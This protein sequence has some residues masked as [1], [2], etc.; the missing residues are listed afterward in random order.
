MGDFILPIGK[1]KVQR[2][3]SDITIVA[4]AR[5]MHESLIAADK[6]AEQGISAEVLNLRTIRPL[7][8]QAIVDSVKKTGRIITVEE[9]WPQSGVG[10]EIAAV[11]MESEAFDYLDAPFGARHR[12]RCAHA[13]RHLPGERRH[14]H[15]RQ[16]RGRGHPRLLPQAVERSEEV[17]VHRLKQ[18]SDLHERDSQE[19]ES[20]SFAR[21]TV[22]S[23][24]HKLDPV[25]LLIEDALTKLVHA[26]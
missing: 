10:S 5:M 16:H 9:G 20:C 23:S 25:I 19:S 12:C 13:L 18:F 7:D 8:N 3:G 4:N 24:R 15:L 17:S 1:A 2:A 11:M 6:L 14:T 21:D 22:L 26:L